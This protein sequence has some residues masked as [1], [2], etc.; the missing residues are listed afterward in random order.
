MTVIFQAISAVA[1]LKLSTPHTKTTNSVCSRKISPL[2]NI[3]GQKYSHL[4][5]T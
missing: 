1:R 4:S 5:H 3:K 2:D